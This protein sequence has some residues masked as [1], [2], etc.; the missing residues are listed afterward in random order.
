VRTEEV[1]MGDARYEV[2]EAERVHNRRGSAAQDDARVLKHLIAAVKNLADRV[3]QLE[4]RV[5]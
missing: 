2:Q 4:Y 1:S 3:E 5:R